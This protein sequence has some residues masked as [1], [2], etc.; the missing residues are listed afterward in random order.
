M[1]GCANVVRPPLFCARKVG[2]AFL[3]YSATRDKDELYNPDKSHPSPVG[4]ALA[5]K[6]I[7]E[8]MFHS[9]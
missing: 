9:R 8:A 6:V 5:A 4:S 3:E 7:A 1:G 2:K